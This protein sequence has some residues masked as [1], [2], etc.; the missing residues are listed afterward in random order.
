LTLLDARNLAE[1]V[2]PFTNLDPCGKVNLLKTIELQSED[3]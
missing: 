3:L 1:D 2:G